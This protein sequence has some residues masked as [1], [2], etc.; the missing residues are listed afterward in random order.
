MTKSNKPDTQYGLRTEKHSV[1]RTIK[2]IVFTYVGVAATWILLSDLLASTVFNDADR[3]LGFNI[4]KGLMFVLITSSLLYLLL[5][6][7][8][9]R[10]ENQVAELRQS[11]E[12]LIRVLAGSQLGFWDWHIA[13]NE[14]K[15]N[16]IWAEMLGYSFGDIEFTTKQWTDFV[17]PDDRERAWASINA[18][19]E[20]RAEEHEMTYRMKTKDGGY[21]WIL[22]RARVVE[23]DAE[24]KPLRMSGTHTDINKL[25]ITEDA[26]QNSEKRFR[27]IFENAAVGIAQ[28]GTD[29]K[30]K[31]INDTYC[32]I[33]G[34]SRDELIDGE[35]S[36]QQI[37]FPDDLDS[38]LQK[39]HQL[40]KGSTNSYDIEKRYVRKDGSIAWVHL[41]VSLI[42]DVYDQPY[43]LIA[44][45]Q[46][47]TNLKMLQEELK[48]QAHIDFLTGV[49]NR[50]YFME[51]AE[52]E[53][54]RLHRYANLLAVIMV[55]VDYFKNI[56]DTYGHKAGDL[57]LQKI[58]QTMLSELRE[59]DIIGR[60][61]GEEFAILLPN[62]DQQHSLEVAGRL[63]AAVANA[64]ITIDDGHSIKI[65]ISIGVALLT[66]IHDSIEPLLNKADRGLYQAKT[67]GRNRIVM[68]D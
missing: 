53:L 12:S 51:L 63:Q 7:Y 50:R 33:T 59:V 42:K 20:G 36:F 65:T 47:I 52:H 48:N 61:G 60:I 17:H 40:L 22:D 10:F 29:G 37:T 46:D 21:K 43:G 14:V 18:V 54:A 31:L 15:R 68:S 6:S 39:K 8:L 13:A 16:A 67:L 44:A 26:L 45:V 34:Y 38:D 28:V 1:R 64:D 57:V 9:T 49:P 62:T 41:S 66:G 35:K 5:R 55:D 11:E 56:N 30:F 32:R 4:V 24:G 3:I 19:L 2:R 25:K 23:R 58:V 27:G